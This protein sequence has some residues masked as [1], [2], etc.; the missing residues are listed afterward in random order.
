VL[1]LLAIAA[2]SFNPTFDLGSSGTSGTA[3]SAVALKTLETGFPAGATDPTMVL[4]RSTDGSPLSPDELTAY[5]QAL[6]E[7]EGVAQ[8]QPGQPSKDGT[9]ASFSVYLNGD[10]ASDAGIAAVKGP[11]REG[12]H[13]AA[14]DG[15]EAL[16]G[17]TTSVFVDF[18]AAMNRDYRVVFPVA[19]LVIMLG[20]PA[21]KL[22]LGAAFL[23]A[24][25]AILALLKYDQK[26]GGFQFISS[27]MVEP[28]LELLPPETEDP[29][30][31]LPRHV[32]D[33][34][35][36]ANQVAISVLEIRN[37]EGAIGPGVSEAGI[38]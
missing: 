34:V 30:R 2:L 22:A 23:Q 7:L 33:A 27:P 36:S 4:L 19:A 10:P 15:T 31:P 37:R 17:G 26:L 14:P 28:V 32:A 20:A 11:I 21:R 3:E 38:I 6:G 9:V 35:K 8:V 29:I 1:G 25:V 13:E 12:A 5:E 24:I 18:Q 16:V